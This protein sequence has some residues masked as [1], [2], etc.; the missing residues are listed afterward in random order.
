MC[1]KVVEKKPRNKEIIW[2]FPEYRVTKGKSIMRL[3]GRMANL[4]GGSCSVAQAS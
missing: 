2:H 3:R 1:E 4:G